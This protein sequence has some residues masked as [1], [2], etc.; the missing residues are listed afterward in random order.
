MNDGNDSS[1]AA[2]GLAVISTEEEE[3]EDDPLLSAN[4]SRTQNGQSAPAK[5]F[6]SPKKVSK[7]KVMGRS[8]AVKVACDYLMKKLK[9]ADECGQQH[10][11]GTVQVKED[12][13]GMFG[14]LLAEKLRHL[15]STTRE[16]VMRDINNII[17]NATVRP[18]LPRSSTPYSPHSF[19]GSPAPSHTSLSSTNDSRSSC[20]PVS[21]MHVPSLNLH[22]Q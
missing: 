13:C 14:R 4:E 20:S 6:E 1:N 5:I 9:R 17:F 21:P 11:A 7:S 2:E 8:D 3:N 22:E 18:H 10:A 19:L 16:H 15:D 12:E